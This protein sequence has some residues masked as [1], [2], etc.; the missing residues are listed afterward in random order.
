ML[1]DNNDWMMDEYSHLAVTT[2]C[3]YTISATL[4]EI[5]EDKYSI[6]RDGIPVRFISERYF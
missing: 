3:V 5:N 2:L 6:L 1:F 4:I